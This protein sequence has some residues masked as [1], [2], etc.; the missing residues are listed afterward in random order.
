[1]TTAVLFLTGI[2]MSAA[3]VAQNTPSAKTSWAQTVV[4]LID[5]AAA[6]RV[7]AHA[8]DVYQAGPLSS[9][10]KCKL[11]IDMSV[12]RFETKWSVNHVTATIK[13]AQIRHIG[14]L[15]DGGTRPS[16]PVRLQSGRTEPAIEE[17]TKTSDDL[18]TT[19]QPITLDLLFDSADAAARFGRGI[20]HAILLCG[21]KTSLD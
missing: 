2:A 19:T 17:V 18:T 7:P 20:S 9:P 4:W 15:T 13:L 6:H 11:E 1:M 14:W 3:G 16:H 21:G 12:A 10:E 8:S 5:F